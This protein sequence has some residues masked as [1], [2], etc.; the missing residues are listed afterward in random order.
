MRAR[1]VLGVVLAVTCAGAIFSFLLRPGG[2]LWGDTEESQVRG[3][4]EA[5][6]LLVDKSIYAAMRRNLH[7]RE[8]ISPS[9]LLSFSKLPEPTSRAASRA[10]EVMEASVQEAVRRGHLQSGPSRLP[11]DALSEG[12]LSAIANLSGCL[13]HMLPPRCPATCL[14]SK[15]RLITGACNNRDHPRWGASNTALA[16]WLPPAYED[17]ISEPRGWNPHFLYRGFPLPPVREV[18]RRI[19]HASNEAVTGDD[20][21]SDLLTAWGQYIDH[22]VAFTPQSVGPPA[23][24]AGADCQLTCEPQSPCFPI[25]I[26]TLRDYV[27]R[28]LGPEAFGRHVGPYRGYDPSVDPSVSNVFS[29]AAFRFG[30]ATIHPLVRR[31]DARFQEHPGSRLPLRDAF[32]RPWRLLEEGG[33]DPVMRGL[34]ARAAKLQVQDQLLNEE[35]TERL[36]VL[37]DAGT[38]DLASINLQRGRDHGLPGYNEWRQFCGLSRLETRADLGAATANGS[39]ADRILA[40]YGHP[41]NIDVWLGG[42]A[43]SFLPGARTGPLFACLVGKQMK[44]L[45][46]GDRFWWEHHGVF[47]E[48]QRR[49]LGRH[50]LSRV[51]CDNTGLTHVPRDAFRVGQWPQDFESCDRIPGMDLRAWREAPPPDDA[52]GFP[53]NVENG[54]FLLCNES[55]RRLLVFSCHHGFQLQGPEQLTCTRRG[56]DSQPPVCRDINECE[57]GVDPPCHA[58]ARCKNTKGGFRCE[59]H[60][61]HVPGEDGRTCVDSGRLPRASVVSL[62]LGAVLVCGLAGLTWTVVCR[63]ML[64]NPKSSLPPVEGEGEGPSWLGRGKPRD[65]CAPPD[66][67]AGLA[68]QGPAC[69]PQVLLCK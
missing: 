30:H 2:L 66:A 16:R 40:L 13:P 54:G 61:P 47:T 41:D 36:F 1:A 24:G 52:C 33:V 6:R 28:I 51:I 50:S 12:L 42:L 56:W 18:T 32:F 57:D 5:S 9:Q 59:C 68:E 53:D 23:P 65:V 58:S 64:A 25:Q 29:T 20:R 8:V 37:S 38:L 31:L 15:Y 17:G 49:E 43:E 48:A 21:Y 63:W 26:I 3:I 22:D 46:D 62:V 67:P 34:L 4:V 11:T 7:K 55:G 14:V 10:A 60:D 35:L 44:A 27:P 69:G 45:R 39:M 19:I